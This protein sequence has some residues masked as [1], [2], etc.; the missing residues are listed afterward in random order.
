[1]SK[2]KVNKVWHEKNILGKNQPLERR[3]IWHLEHEKNCNCRE[4]PKSIRDEIKKR[5]LK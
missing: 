2:S 1:M 3:I 5:N 4:M